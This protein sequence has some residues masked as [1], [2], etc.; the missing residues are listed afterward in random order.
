MKKAIAL[1]IVL[2]FITLIISLLIS[3]YAIYDKYSNNNFEK[4]ISQ[5]SIIIHN[6]TPILNNLSKKIKNDDD[7]K[8]IC[9]KYPNILIN[10]NIK[11]D[12]EITPL[13]NRININQFSTKNI[14]INKFLD[15]IF[16]VY[17]ISNIDFFK[18]LLLDTIDTDDKK[19]EFNTEIK[20]ENPYFQD[21]GIYSYKHFKMI[22]NYFVKN[23]KD[24][25][26][27]KV[28]W[29]KLFYFKTI[30][31]NFIDCN[32][33]NKEF[34]KILGLDIENINCN[35]IKENIDK[36]LLKELAIIPFKT[37]N[38]FYLEITVKYYLNNIESILYFIYDIKTKK[39]IS[40]E[41]HPIY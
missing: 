22:L 9:G 10:D 14:G 27:Y 29:K 33:I 30:K 5:D 19:R 40:F 1:M 12:V 31:T 36:Q 35:T 3:I 28:P 34:I 38:P 41:K 2:G 13:F 21:G 26:I 18:N 6:I 39:V 25:N 8:R 17:N 11:M 4:T 7:L 24:Y 37:K 16:D 20:F 23:T 15:N 32:F